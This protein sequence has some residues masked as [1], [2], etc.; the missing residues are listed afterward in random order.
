MSKESML[1]IEIPVINLHD[2]VQK[3]GC[4][5]VTASFRIFFQRRNAMMNVVTDIGIYAMISITCNA[6]RTEAFPR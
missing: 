2:S 1:C 3:S 5:P 6:P 4:N